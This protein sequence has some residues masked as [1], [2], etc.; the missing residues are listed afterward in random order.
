MI[1]DCLAQ[2]FLLPDTGDMAFMEQWLIRI[3]RRGCSKTSV[4]EQPRLYVIFEFREHQK[5]NTNQR[6]NGLTR[7]HIPMSLIFAPHPCRGLTPHPYRGMT[8]P[9][10]ITH[11]PPPKKN[12]KKSNLQYPK[13]IK[14]QKR[15]AQDHMAGARQFASPST[16]RANIPFKI[17]NPSSISLSLMM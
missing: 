7:R 16:Y 8:L 17:A 5:N 3:G 11:P 12:P 1:L 10:P 2:R 15:M 9:A 14:K 13:K 4:L 6:M